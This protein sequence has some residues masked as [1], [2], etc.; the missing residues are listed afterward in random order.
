MIKACFGGLLLSAKNNGTR[1]THARDEKL[2]EE[3][4]RD[5][6]MLDEII[7]VILRNAATKDLIFWD[8]SRKLPS[9]EVKGSE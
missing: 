3:K 2:N 4:L 1:P 5:K 9:S 7:A 8:S 6:S